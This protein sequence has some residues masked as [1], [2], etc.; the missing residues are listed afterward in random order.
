MLE[1]LQ[2]TWL[3]NHGHVLFWCLMFSLVGWKNEDGLLSSTPELV[4]GGQARGP[5][6]NHGDAKLLVVWWG[7]LRAAH[8]DN[9]LRCNPNLRWSAVY[10]LR[11]PCLSLSRQSS[12]PPH[13]TPYAPSDPQLIYCPQAHLS[14]LILPVLECNTKHIHQMTRLT[15]HK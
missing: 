10:P 9:E 11:S 1:R 14:S 3:Y 4:D 12:S 5:I 2:T 7:H 13:T 6:C 8:Q 15:L